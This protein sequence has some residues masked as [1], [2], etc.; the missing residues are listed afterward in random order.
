MCSRGHWRPAEDEK[1][2]ELV[3]RYGPHNWNAIAEKLHGRSGDYI[4]CI[5]Q[6]LSKYVGEKRE[7]MKK[8]CYM[9]T[10][11]VWYWW[12][13]K[14]ATCKFRWKIETVNLIGLKDKE[15]Y[16]LKDEIYQSKMTLI[17]NYFIY[18]FFFHF[19]FLI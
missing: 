14:V 9:Y 7:E 1:L 13:N 15:I 18:S 19:F 16:I 6:S 12:L 11:R 4:M 3:E 8:G 10:S 17:Y 2:R 5:Q